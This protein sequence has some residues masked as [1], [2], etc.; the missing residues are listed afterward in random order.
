MILVFVLR[1]NGSRGGARRWPLALGWIVRDQPQNLV[2]IT[3]ETAPFCKAA[4][5][6]GTIDEEAAQRSLSLGVE[7][8]LT[9]CLMNVPAVREQLG[10]ILVTAPDGW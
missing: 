2:Y 6:V 10:V 8:H 5:S 3:K 9:N 7:Y 4:A 1:Q